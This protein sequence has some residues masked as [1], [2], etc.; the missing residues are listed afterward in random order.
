M[1][2]KNE[3]EIYNETKK[4]AVE[5]TKSTL[6]PSSF[7][8]PADAW[9]AILYGR[10]L[11]LRAIYSLNNI[12]V[13]NGKPGLSADAMLGLCMKNPEFG[14]YSVDKETN[15]IC[16][17]TMTRKFPNGT[18]LT[19]TVSFTIEEAKQAGLLDTKSQMYNKYPKR[20][21]RARA[22]A[23][24]CREVFADIFAET[25][26]G[27]EMEDIP[28]KIETP[29]YVVVEGAASNDNELAHA[30]REC[31]DGIKRLSPDI[32]AEYTAKAKEALDNGMLD[33]LESLAVEID[34][35][36]HKP[37]PAPAPAP[38]PDP[39]RGL[40]V[41]KG[42]IDTMN[43]LAAT[44]NY[45]PKH[46][47]NSIKRQLPD[48]NFPSD[49][50]KQAILSSDV[51]EAD[52]EK[53]LKYWKDRLIDLRK[54]NPPS[55]KKEETLADQAR[56]VA[57]KVGTEEAAATLEEANKLAEGGDDNGYKLI[58]ETWGE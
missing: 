29:D 50:W 47:M 42:I 41:K 21:L 45:A 9:Y 40:S 32:A 43:K 20:M 18:N 11:G 23:Y 51:P 8:N 38:A 54:A 35:A 7:K 31:Q 56:R 25:Y 26:T 13:I 22:M 37:A 58:I 34:I 2:I 27:E 53:A 24:V 12:S 55:Q 30:M 4:I 16:T 39:E 52:L 1:D 14:G 57:D 44:G 46:I 3:L 6:I 36:S 28:N 33:A 17:I 15:D 5:L 49:D 19:R 48:I 10:E